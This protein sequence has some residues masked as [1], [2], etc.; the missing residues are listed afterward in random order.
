MSNRA[1]S[2]SGEGAWSIP[3]IESIERAELT[4]RQKWAVVALRQMHP[5][6]APFTFITAYLNKTFEKKWTDGQVTKA[7]LELR[8]EHLAAA[9]TPFNNPFVEVVEDFEYMP[10]ARKERVQ[11]L[12][13]HYDKVLKEWIS[14]DGGSVTYVRHWEEMAMETDPT[15][16]TKSQFL[17]GSKKRR[18]KAELL[19]QWITDTNNGAEPVMFKAS[20]QDKTA[21]QRMEEYQ[22]A[23]EESASKKPVFEP[24]PPGS[25]VLGKKQ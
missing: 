21:A 5:F 16:H 7:Y 22:A 19:E 2:E 25:K 6:I 18:G 1:V 24:A 17:L 23:K 10:E 13:R 3:S 12:V 14:V 20:L 11:E 4:D 9:E 15:I 8:R